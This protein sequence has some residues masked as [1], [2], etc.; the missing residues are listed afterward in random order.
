MSLS[1]TEAVNRRISVRAF[2]PKPVPSRRTGTRLEACAG[3]LR[4]AAISS[5]G[6]CMCLAASCWTNA[7]RCAE[8]RA[9]GVREAPQYEVYPPNLWEPYRSYRFKTGEDLYAPIGVA[10]EDKPARLCSTL[11]MSDIVKEL[12]ESNKEWQREAKSSSAPYRCGGTIN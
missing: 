6:R 4:A 10:R 8:R 1:V 12:V 3:R 5:P 7:V 9:A 2:L 11:L